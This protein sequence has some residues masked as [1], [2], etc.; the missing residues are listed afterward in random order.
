[1]ERI[2]ASERTREKLKSL[3]EG[4]SEE[5]GGSAL[6]RR[7]ARLIIEEALE[8]EAKN[9]VGPRLLRARWCARCGLPQRLPAWPGEECGGSDRVQ[10]AADR[11]S[12]PAVS[13]AAA[14]AARQ[15]HEGAGG[16]GG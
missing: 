10:R 3:M 7:A 1:M 13:L 8:A 9:A 6:V 5:A 2:A 12:R 15:A 11:G 14:R 16:A 4:L